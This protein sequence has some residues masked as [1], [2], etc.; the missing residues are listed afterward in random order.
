MKAFLTIVLAT[1]FLIHAAMVFTPPGE[2][3]RIKAIGPLAGL[4]EDHKRA[5]DA[6]SDFSP[7][8]VPKPGDWLAEHREQGQTFS[9]YLRSGYNR[10]DNIRKKIYLQPLGTFSEDGSPSSDIL[11]EFT[12]AYFAM[13]A[14]ILPSSS[15]KGQIF[16][17][18]INTI[19]GKRQILTGDVLKFL[20]TRL[21]SDGFCILAITMED[22]YPD[23]AWNF[24]FGQASLTERTGVYSFA[25]YDPAFYGQKRGSDYWNIFLKRCCKVLAHETGHMFGLQHCIFFKCLMNGSN[26]LEESDSRLLHLCPVCLR[27]LQHSTGFDIIKRYDKLRVFCKD[28][29]FDEEALWIRN[30]LNYIS[31]NL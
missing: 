26:H 14:E 30:R 12:C 6:G 5:F 9:E 19:T 24:V 8:G 11:R 27:K 17:T 21:P 4:P 3:E 29:G 13:D 1:A 18:R 31:G 25:H 16:T 15:L 10:P 22:L 23:P 7:M 28:Q 20:Q 2:S